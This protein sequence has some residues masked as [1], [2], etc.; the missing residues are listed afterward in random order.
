MEKYEKVLEVMKSKPE[1]L[2]AVDDADLLQVLGEKLMY[3]LPT[4]IS[5]IRRV[6]K[7]EVLAHRKGRKVVSYQLAA[8]KTDAPAAE[9]PAPAESEAETPAV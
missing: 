7:L 4:Y 6:P 8:L 9:T 3:R 5:Q 2:V 1:G